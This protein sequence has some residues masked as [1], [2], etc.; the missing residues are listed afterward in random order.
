[1]FFIPK[2]LVL[3]PIGLTKVI[4]REV[5]CD[6]GAIPVAVGSTKPFQKG[7]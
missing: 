2:S 1:M 7:F 5:R 4:K 3:R 6:A